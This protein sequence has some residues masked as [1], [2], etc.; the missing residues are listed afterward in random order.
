MYQK[1]YIYYPKT[2]VHIVFSTPANLVP[3]DEE[4]TLVHDLLPAAL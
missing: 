2:P 1:K 4:A 3:S